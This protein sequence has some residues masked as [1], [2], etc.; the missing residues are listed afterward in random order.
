M[1]EKV[2]TQIMIALGGSLLIAA[3]VLMCCFLCLFCKL[4]SIL[5]APKAPVCLALKNNPAMVTQDKVT[6]ATPITTGLDP[7]FQYCVERN[8][9]DKFDP[10]PPCFCDGNEGF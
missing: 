6:A 7:N 2:D 3:F 10:L 4:A 1:I 5:R 8:F 9:Y